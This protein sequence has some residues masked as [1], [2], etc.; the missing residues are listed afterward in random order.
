MTNK[1]K[2]ITTL[3]LS[4]LI[5]SCSSTKPINYSIEDDPNA[6]YYGQY[7]FNVEIPE[8][9]F[10]FEALLTIGRTKRGIITARIIWTFQGQSF[11]D[12]VVRSLVISDGQISFNSKSAGGSSSDV[13]FYFTGENK[14]EGFATTVADPTYVVPVGT[15]FKLEGLKVE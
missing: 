13:Q 9:Q 15:V 14:I 11:Y 4:M 6:Q 1:T 12:S 2:G 7:E 10:P 8:V 5:L 3:V